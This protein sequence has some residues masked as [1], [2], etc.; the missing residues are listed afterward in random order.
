MVL[1][2]LGVFV[3]G[4]DLA[5]AEAG[6]RRRAARR[7]RRARPAAVAGREVARDARR[8]RRRHALPHARD[9]PRLRAREARAARRRGGDRGAAL[10]SLLRDG[11]GGAGRAERARAGRLDAA[12]RGR[13]RQRARRDRAGARG[14]RRSDHRGQVR[15]R[16]A[17]LL[18]P[19]RL[20]DAKAASSCSAAL[21][22]PAVQASPIAQAH[23]LYV[24]AALAESQSDH[25]E[26]RQMLETCLA[27]RRALGNR[28]RH[29]GHAVDAVAGPPA[30]G[31]RRRG[32]AGESEAL[33]IF[34]R[35]GD[36]DRRGDRPAPSRARSGCTGA[37]TRGPLASGAVPGDRARDPAPGARGRVRAGARRGRARD[38]RC[39]PGAASASSAR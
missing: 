32:R 6:V 1:D 36:R 38:G 21:A 3:G 4:F 28:G 9:D 12:R 35:L 34:R 2:R 11:Q 23:A 24:G 7:R 5:A 39:G 18:D 20:L 31:R 27:L 16:D 29:R 19:A 10:R 15:G 37:T 30:G 26:A 8:A 33:E 13:A 25:A 14:R 22:L 17:G